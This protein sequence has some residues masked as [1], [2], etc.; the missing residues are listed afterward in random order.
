M[1]AIRV[2]VVTGSNKGI[3]LAIVSRLCKEFDGEVILTSRNERLGKEAIE[4]LEAEGLKPKYHQLDITSFESIDRLKQ[5]LV[6]QYGGLDVLVN[7]AGIAY[8]SAS[9][10]LYIQFFPKTCVFWERIIGN[11]FL[12]Q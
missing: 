10:G 1:S 9:T 5:H 4:K 11:S 3:G 2:A 6:Q 8:K 12:K 7:N